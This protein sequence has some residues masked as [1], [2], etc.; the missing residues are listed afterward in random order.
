[1]PAHHGRCHAHRGPASENLHNCGRVHRNQGRVHR[2]KE[3]SQSP[4][5]AATCHGADMPE[6][7]YSIS[8]RARAASARP[9]IHSRSEQKVVGVHIQD[10]LDTNAA[11][12]KCQYGVVAIDLDRYVSIAFTL[13]QDVVA[14]VVKRPE[15]GLK[16]SEVNRICRATM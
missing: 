3:F 14:V 5:R 13:L 11:L 9:A 8:W 16:G 12:R 4:C 15:A 7:G 6:V 2:M 1:M 10:V